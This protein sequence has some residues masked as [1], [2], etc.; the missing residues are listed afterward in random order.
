MTNGQ[1][2]MAPREPT[3]EMDRYNAE[4]LCDLAGKINENALLSI[5]L[6]TE[7]AKVKCLQSRLDELTRALTDIV[8]TN[9][10]YVEEDLGFDPEGPLMQRARSA[11]QSTQKEVRSRTRLAPRCDDC[12]T[13]GQPCSRCLQA[14]LTPN[15]EAGR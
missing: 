11:L 9:D 10:K 2:A 8:E 1:Y 5:R 6:R 14:A 15:K 3:E 4:L 13:D 12:P 7:Q